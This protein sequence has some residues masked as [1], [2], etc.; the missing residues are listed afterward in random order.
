MNNNI[1]EAVKTKS[2]GVNMKSKQ[3]GA[4]TTEAMIILGAIVLAV[5]II[6]LKRPDI[7]YLMDQSRFSSQASEIADAGLR[8]KKMRPN[9]SG[10]TIAKLCTDKYLPTTV[11]GTTNDGKKTNPFGGDWTVDPNTNPALLD[12]TATIPNDPERINDLADYMA[13]VTRSRCPESAG[14]A[15]LTKSGTSIK[16]TF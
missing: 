16:M 8:W 6:M 7:V 1:F 2:A 10:V 15:T 5:V 13:P 4:M 12:V 14:C 11:C 3:R 9:Y